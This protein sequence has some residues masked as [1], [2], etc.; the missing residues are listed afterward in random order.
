L[1]V[2]AAIETVIPDS[3]GPGDGPSPSGLAD[4][5]SGAAMVPDET[6]GQPG[7]ADETA[8]PEPRYCES[9]CA[10]RYGTN[11]PDR[12]DCAGDGRCSYLEHDDWFG[13]DCTLHGEP[14]P[15]RVP[16]GPPDPADREQADAAG[17][18]VKWGADP[19]DTAALAREPEGQPEGEFCP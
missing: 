16:A 2:G 5:T 19:D 9:G 8:A 7:V 10:C 3:A 15:Q 13:P 6:P 14:L 4:S 11:D 18:L 12:L 17:L 1:G